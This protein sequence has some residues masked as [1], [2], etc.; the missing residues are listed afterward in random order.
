MRNASWHPFCA[1]AIQR[2]SKTSAEP[3]STDAPAAATVNGIGGSSGK[4]AEEAVMG[5][6]QQALRLIRVEVFL[7]HEEMVQC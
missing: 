5:P 7:H 3:R 2:S 4:S 6:L 1:S